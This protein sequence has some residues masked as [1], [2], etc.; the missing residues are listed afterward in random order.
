M[1]KNMQLRSWRWEE[2][3]ISLRDLGVGIFS[4]L[5]VVKFAKRHNM[6]R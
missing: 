6:R 4:G 5:R 3:L 2:Y 1:Y